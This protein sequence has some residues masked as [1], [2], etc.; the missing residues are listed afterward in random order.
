[1]TPKAGNG[2][3]D[4]ALISCLFSLV[5]RHYSMLFNTQH[6]F[7]QCHNNIMSKILGE[8]RDEAVAASKVHYSGQLHVSNDRDTE[9]LLGGELSSCFLL[10]VS[11][12]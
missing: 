2:P 11:F 5:P 9:C 4:E 12:D 8:P 7:V 6:T 10:I 1:M 3:G